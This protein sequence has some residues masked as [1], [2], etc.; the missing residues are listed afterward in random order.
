ARVPVQNAIT[1][2]GKGR[3]P[4][5]FCTYASPQCG[6]PLLE[7][8]GVAVCP[9]TAAVPEA[10]VNAWVCVAVAPAACAPL[11]VPATSATAV[12]LLVTF[13]W[14]W[15]NGVLC[16]WLA[17]ACVCVVAPPVPPPSPAAAAPLRNR[18]R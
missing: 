17:R 10:M 6:A 4:L 13:G 3:A 11:T 14:V 2:S 18:P 7:G 8:G 12:W 15:A 1:R 16:V 9:V 5:I